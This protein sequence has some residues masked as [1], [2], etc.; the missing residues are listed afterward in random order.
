MN[1]LLPFTLAFLAGFGGLFASAELLVN[2]AIQLARRFAVSPLIIGLTVVAFGTSAPEMAVSVLASISGNPGIAL[3]NVVGSNIANIGLILGISALI[4]SI[5][6]HERI[7]KME[8]PLLIF[9]SFFLVGAARFD[10]F[11]PWTGILLLTV[12]VAYSLAIYKYSQQEE[13]ILEQQDES[14]TPRPRLAKAAL[15]TAAGLAGLILASKALIWGASGMAA[16]LEIS[17]MTIG[18]T[19]TALGTSLPE[20]ATSI[21]AARRKQ[22]DI[23]LGNVIGS[24]LANSTLVLGLSSLFAHISVTP[25]I[26]H[27]DFLSMLAFTLLLFILTRGG[28][29]LSHSAG[30]L[31]LVLYFGYIALLFR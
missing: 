30:I 27:R 18:L 28:K 24:N 14:S 10:A 23:V 1:T 22:A 7:L 26:L 25:L 19:I 11:G 13:V 5:R 17:Q 9:I 12:F 15:Y 4:H 31:F 8:I 21:A 20:L 29:R 3:G 16:L 2:G 6:P